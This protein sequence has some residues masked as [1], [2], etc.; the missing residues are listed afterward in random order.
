MRTHEVDDVQQRHPPALAVVHEQPRKRVSAVRHRGDEAPRRRT[1]APVDA[2]AT[3]VRGDRVGVRQAVDANRRV[4]QHKAGGLSHGDRRRG[5]SLPRVP[6]QQV[7]DLHLL[8]HCRAVGR[9]LI[10]PFWIP[11]DRVL[12]V[13]RSRCDAVTSSHNTVRK[14]DHSQQ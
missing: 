3:G 2:A 5:A 1:L 12:G 9:E 6:R 13:N 8:I 11:E 4:L 10:D 14:C 7:D